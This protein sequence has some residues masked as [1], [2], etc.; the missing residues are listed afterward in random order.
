M[1]THYV[2]LWCRQT[3]LALYCVTYTQLHH[4]A[5][6]LPSADTPWL[7]VPLRGRS[8]FWVKKISETGSQ[9]HRTSRW[10]QLKLVSIEKSPSL[11]EDA[12]RFLAKSARPSSHES[13]GKYPSAA[14]F[15][16]W[17]L[18]KQLPTGDKKILTPARCSLRKF[19]R[20][21]AFIAPPI[22]KR[23]MTIKKSSLCHWEQILNFFNVHLPIFV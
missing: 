1:Q 6:Q 23:K 16:N 7:S 17:H 5:L 22:D 4:P 13:P 14:M 18:W 2:R 9:C 10:I 21:G 12:R 19:Q 11:N 3:K 15:L 8:L 20:R